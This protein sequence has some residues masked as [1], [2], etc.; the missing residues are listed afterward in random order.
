VWTDFSA[1]DFTSII[2]GS[3]ATLNGNLAANRLAIGS[4]VSGLSI[5]NNATFGI[6]WIDVDV[7]GSEDGLAIDDLSLSTTTAQS[8]VPEPATWAMFIGGFGLVG[9]ALRRRRDT[10]VRFA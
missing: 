4:T 7:S 5:A 6:R 1:L 9:G 2:G 8:V 10:V 3:A